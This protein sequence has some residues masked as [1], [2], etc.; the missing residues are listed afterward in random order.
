MTGL[1]NDSSD[2]DSIDVVIGSAYAG[3]GYPAHHL[4]CQGYICWNCGSNAKIDAWS[5]D[6]KYKCPECYGGDCGNLMCPCALEEI[7]RAMAKQFNT[8]TSDSPDSGE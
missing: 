8:S 5:C 6:H 7:S 1:M 3:S 2:D 4:R